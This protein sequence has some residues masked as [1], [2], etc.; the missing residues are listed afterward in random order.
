MLQLYV[1]DVNMIESL[2]Y[3]N[4]WNIDIFDK[5]GKKSQLN[6]RKFKWISEKEL[7]VKRI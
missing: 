2:L 3:E 7:T 1:I 6:E 5:K 4:L